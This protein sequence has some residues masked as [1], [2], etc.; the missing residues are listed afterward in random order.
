MPEI[1][2]FFGIVITMPPNDH[3]P[4]HF[5]AAYGGAFATIAIESGGLI[6][7]ELPPRI[8]GLI[9]E[10]TSLHRMALRTNWDLVRAGH[11]VRRIAPLE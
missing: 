10:W 11:P 4:P 7:G 3:L 9:S 1:S 5:H 6:R 8:L 2:R